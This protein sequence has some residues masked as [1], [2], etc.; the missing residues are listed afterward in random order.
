MEN[1]ALSGKRWHKL[2]FLM[3]H[4]VGTVPERIVPKAF[5]EH[6]SSSDSVF[7][8]M[9]FSFCHCFCPVLTKPVFLQVDLSSNGTFGWLAGEHGGT[10]ADSRRLHKLPQKTSTSTWGL[11]T[12]GEQI[13][14]SVFGQCVSYSPKRARSG[15][16][17]TDDQA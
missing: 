16:N 3:H 13:M 10:M 8:K 4:K 17:S 7:D 15:S 14:A 11:P 9:Y 5:S 6:F 12:E 2:F 1:V